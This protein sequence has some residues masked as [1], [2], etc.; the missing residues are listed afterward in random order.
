MITI[1]QEQYNAV[2]SVAAD[3]GTTPEEL[4]QL[5]AFESGFNPT[6]KNPLPDSTARGLIQ[7]I[8]STAQDLGF[9]N[10][11]DLVTKYPT[12]TT[13]LNTPVRN[14]LKKYAP[15]PTRQALYM[16]VFYPAAQYWP[17][18]KEFPERV[19][20]WNPGIKTPADYLRL[21]TRKAQTIQIQGGG[22]IKPKRNYWPIVAIVAASAAALYFINR[23]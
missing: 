5:I 17:S 20:S 1:T 3:I 22:T 10:S 21:A 8:D 12:V 19:Q 16:A 15:Y 18:D 9:N 13:Q 14:Y 7:F 23:E 2:K 4:A 11:L 6:I